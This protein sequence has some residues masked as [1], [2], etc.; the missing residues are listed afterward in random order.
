MRWGMRCFILVKME[1]MNHWVFWTQI[2]LDWRALLKWFFPRHYLWVLLKNSWMPHSWTSST[3]LLVLFGRL[4]LFIK[5]F[6]REDVRSWIARDISTIFISRGTRAMNKIIS[7]SVILAMDCSRTFLDFIRVP[8]LSGSRWRWPCGTIAAEIDIY[9]YSRVTR[10]FCAFQ[11][12]IED[13]ISG[14]LIHHRLL[15]IETF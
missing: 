1:W 13:A 3:Y 2:N 9:E 7:G 8:D 11:E 15:K 4:N 5:S 10:P 6:S 12:G 14:G